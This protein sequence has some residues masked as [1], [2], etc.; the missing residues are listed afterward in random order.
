MN[1]Q[2]LAALG[3]HAKV[4]LCE[5]DPNGLGK[6][7]PRARIQGVRTVT[8]RTIDLPLTQARPQADIS[9]RDPGRETANNLHDSA[10]L[11]S[12]IQDGPSAIAQLATQ[13]VCTY[14]EK[15]A[16]A[17]GSVEELNSLIESTFQTLHD[18]EMKR[19][20]TAGD[21]PR[22]NAP[23]ASAPHPE[24]TAQPSG[25][26]KTKSAPSKTIALPDL[27]RIRDER[28]PR[29]LASA[30]VLG[31][32]ADGK[33]VEFDAE[34]WLKLFDKP[35]DV[36]IAEAR[37][38]NPYNKRGWIGV[39]DDKIVCLFTGRHLK[40][41]GAHLRRLFKNDPNYSAFATHAGYVEG[42]NLPIDYPKAAPY[43][44][45]IRTDV[46]A[47]RGK[48]DTGRPAELQKK[49]DDVLEV[50]GFD[51]SLRDKPATRP[52]NFPDFV[53]CLECGDAMHD[54]RPH[55]RDQHGTYYD[56][57]KRDWQIS[58]RAPATGE[59]GMNFTST[60]KHAA[61]LLEDL[62]IPASEQIQPDRWPGVLKDKIL[63]M[64]DN[65][66]VDDLPKHLASTGLPPIKHYLARYELPEDYPATPP[67]LP[68][69]AGG[70]E[71]TKAV[72]SKRAASSSKAPAK[73]GRVAKAAND[74]AIV[75]QSPA[76][77]TTSV[78]LVAQDKEND[79]ATLTD[80]LQ[81]DVEAFKRRKSTPAVEA[82]PI[83]STV[84]PM[85]NRTS[86]ETR[87]IER[88]NGALPV[89]IER[90]PGK[91]RLRK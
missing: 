62:G 55:L 4:G 10:A 60:R 33:P 3:A 40:I 6:T 59:E 58:G 76:A 11:T 81:Q 32:S 51:L 90:R 17:I 31:V 19:V 44:S 22:Q 34:E 56:R 68:P 53:V 64:I 69:Q 79:L 25:A 2:H 71:T 16:A 14:L 23:I 21:G 48:G 12:P 57:Y 41:L 37:S 45:T 24:S 54:I 30:A 74:E 83:T 20:E 9:P 5:H 35:T 47:R 75:S 89:T 82:A 27:Q 28:R 87:V 86:V 1:E 63:C 26:P 72:R 91:L 13:I 18:F 42:L 84:L 39:Y 77:R 50:S 73:R 36:M 52:G 38:D 85:P 70:A 49:I 43:L 67:S 66:L 65:Q 78:D 29:N 88:K 15:N 7:K 8:K 80:K 46:A 61:Q